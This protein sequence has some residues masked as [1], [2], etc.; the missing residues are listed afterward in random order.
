MFLLNQGDLPFTSGG[1]F[2]V[3]TFQTSVWIGGDFTDR[4]YFQQALGANANPFDLAL[5]W[6]TAEVLPFQYFVVAHGSTQVVQLWLLAV[7]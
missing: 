1:F 7:E 3:V 6:D 4:V 5:L 2:K